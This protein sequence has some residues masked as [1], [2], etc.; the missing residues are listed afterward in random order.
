[1]R[2]ITRKSIKDFLNTVDHVLN[3]NT[4]LFD[5][6]PSFSEDLKGELAAF[7]QSADFYGRM[8]QQDMEGG[9]ITCISLTTGQKAINPGLETW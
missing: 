8:L 5:Y 6:K 3:S 9:G 2:D 1:M 7:L 4:F